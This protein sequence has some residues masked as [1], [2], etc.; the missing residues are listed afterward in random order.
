[1]T[2]IAFLVSVIRTEF[3]H[4]KSGV[5]GLL[6]KHIVVSYDAELKLRLFSLVSDKRTCPYKL[7]VMALHLISRKLHENRTEIPLFL[8]LDV[9]KRQGVWQ[10]KGR[11]E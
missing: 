11:A 5:L 9:Y 6:V 1:M 3:L 2:Q 10:Q 8:E 7:P 4:A